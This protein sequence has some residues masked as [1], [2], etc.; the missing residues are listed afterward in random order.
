[1][2]AAGAA[3]DAAGLVL[4]LARTRLC[5]WHLPGGEGG[6]QCSAGQGCLYAIIGALSKRFYPE[7]LMVPSLIF[8]NQVQQGTHLTCLCY[9]FSWQLQV[10][11]YYK[12]LRS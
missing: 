1:V 7:V 4:V 12:A 9:V 6:G 3:C 2:E 10:E 11:L 8:C 5:E